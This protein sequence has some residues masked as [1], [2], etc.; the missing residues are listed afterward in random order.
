MRQPNYQELLFDKFYFF[1]NGYATID[2]NGK[3]GVIDRSYNMVIPFEYA[4]LGKYSEGLF[5]AKQ[6]DKYGYIDIYNN[7]VIK[8]EYDYGYPFSEQLAL[9]IKDDKFQFI[10]RF[11]RVAIPFQYEDACS[12]S[13]G[14]AAVCNSEEKFGFID[15]QGNLVIPYKYD[16]ADPFE[17]GLCYVEQGDLCGFINTKGEEVIPCIYYDAEQLSN[18]YI[19]VYLEDKTTMILDRNGN[20]VPWTV[21]YD[22]V[23]YFE[24]GLA[25]VSKDKKWGMVDVNGNLVIPCIYDAQFEHRK[26]DKLLVTKFKDKWGAIDKNQNVVIPFKYNKS[27]RCFGE[28]RYLVENSAFE[29]LVVDEYN[30][31]VFRLYKKKTTLYLYF[32]IAAVIV[33]LVLYFFGK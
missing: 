9:V 8:P 30:Y 11:N 3:Y 25:S 29:K 32:F 13:E 33:G 15:V 21:G 16:F 14:L 17:N 24:D 31:E 5:P 28:N 23:G 26:G 19:Y 27:V 2:I 4:M 7:W 6:N 20:Q 1:E 12:F 10:D 22:S 18:Q